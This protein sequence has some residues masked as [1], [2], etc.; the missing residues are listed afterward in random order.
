[1]NGVVSQS[2]KTIMHSHKHMHV[3]VLTTCSC[4]TDYVY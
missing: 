4:T 3:L 2:K 1:L